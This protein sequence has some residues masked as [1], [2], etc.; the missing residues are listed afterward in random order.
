MC[1]AAKILADNP[2]CQTLLRQALQSGFSAAT[3]ENRQPTVQEI[4]STS[5]PYLDAAMEE[6]L[7]VGGVVPLNSRETTR[8]TQ[9]LGHVIPKDTLVM[10]LANGPGT[11]MPS[12]E[13]NEK[14]RS[15][16]SQQDEKDGRFNDWGKDDIELFKPERWL[17]RQ[18][19]SVTFDA[20]AGPSMPFGLGARACFGRRLAYVSFR[21][22]L[23]MVIWNFELLECP[24][25]LSDYTGTF[26]VVYR[27]RE[28]YV[29]LRKISPTGAA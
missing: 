2:R 21:I 7:R 24:E 23:V 27:P 10:F 9:L 8:P 18:S 1:W 13:V 14:S 26:G 11:T 29:R 25:T 22:L 28:T 19:D 4:F 17:V 15:E 5:I 12:Y 3:S 16:S 6:L 20:K